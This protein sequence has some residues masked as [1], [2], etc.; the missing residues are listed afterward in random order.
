MFFKE[1]GPY[2]VT[3]LNWIFI[4][5]WYLTK[6]VMKSGHQFY[7]C[8][9]I[10]L[11]KCLEYRHKFWVEFLTH[12]QLHVWSLQ[13]KDN[14]QY[15]LFHFYFL[16]R[17]FY[18][19]TSFNHVDKFHGLGKCHLYFVNPSNKVGSFTFYSHI[20]AG[21]GNLGGVIIPARYAKNIFQHAI[22]PCNYY[23]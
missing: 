13:D 1:C 16:W 18:V 21:L 5:E 12:L 2:M 4:F 9:E 3:L 20:E 23:S 7:V 19:I 10:G 8:D 11:G 22:I 6:L 17:L 15:D 14:C